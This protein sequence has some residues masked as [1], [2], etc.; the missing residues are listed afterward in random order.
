MWFEEYRLYLG[1]ESLVRVPDVACRI[2]FSAR[3]ID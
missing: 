3:Y 1:A 2:I